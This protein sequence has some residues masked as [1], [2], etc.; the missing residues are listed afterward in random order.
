MAVTAL[1]DLRLDPEILDQGL[2]K[3]R[4]ILSVTRAVDGCLGVQI[5]IDETDPAHVVVLETW[6]SIEHDDAYRKWR[7][8]EGRSDLPSV[9][10]APAVL[11]R[12]PSVIDL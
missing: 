7:A 5:M 4:E 8:G 3:L 6:A 2:H 1:L 12:F 9:L 10:A 11:T